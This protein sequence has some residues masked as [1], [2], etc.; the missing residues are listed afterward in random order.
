MTNKYGKIIGITMGDAAGIGPEIILNSFINKNIASS[1]IIII[2]NYDV[3]NKV[4]NLLGIKVK[5]NKI[6]NVSEAKF[7]KN[8]L[9]IVHFNNIDI[10]KLTPGK[11]QAMAGKAAFEY[12]KKSVELA[13]NKEIDAVVTAPLN[14]ESMHLAG[15]KFPGHTEIFAKYTKTQNYAM[16]LYSNKLKV[17][18]VSTHMSLQNAICKLSTRRVEKVIQLAHDFMKKLGV[19]NPKIGVAGINPHAGEGGLFGKEELKY[20][21]P[22]IISKKNEGINVE[23]PIPPDT[24]FI[25]GIKRI[26]NVI[27]AMYHDQG[28]I[29]FKLL[30]FNKGVNITVGI[31]IIR[32]SVDHGVAFDIAW[33]GRADNSSMIQAIRLAS[34]LVKSK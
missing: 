8:T 20:I 24:I 26:Y 29:P 12:V 33:K 2:G 6:H 15:Y 13:L 18:F 17:I 34:R 27:I 3:I 21:F 16:F 4:R 1:K 30:A 31:P 32:T 5:L 11:V 10:N 7:E 22:A 19:K 25:K 23:G 14:K 9:D 28:C